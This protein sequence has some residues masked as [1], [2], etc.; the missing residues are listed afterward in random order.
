MRILEE[1]PDDW[2]GH[3]R[4]RVPD[5]RETT[6]GNAGNARLSRRSLLHATGALAGVGVLGLG[7]RTAS[8]NGHERDQ[9]DRLPRP[10]PDVLYEPLAS[11]PQLE[12]TGVWNADPLLVSGTDAYVDGEYLY[13]DYVYDDYG[14]NTTDT[15]APPQPAP[16]DSNAYGENG[17]MTGDVVY[18][19]D[20]DTYRYNAA[21]LLELRATRAGNDVTYRITL[22]T[23]VEPDA[24]AVAIGIDTGESAGTDDWGYGIGS[25]GSLNL[26]HV[27]V[28]WGERAELD[29]EPV[30]SSVDLKRNQIEVTLPLDP[31]EETWRHYAVVGLFDTTAKRF[32]P[33]QNGTSSTHPG[34][35]HGTNPPPVFNVG[36]RFDE[37]VGAP[38]VDR[39]TAETQLEEATTTGS[40]GIGF[41]HWRDHAQATALADRDISHLHTD[42]DFG[43][44]RRRVDERNVPDS[45]LLTRLYAS[46]YDLGEGV[47]AAGDVLR[48]PIQPYTVYVPDEYD[49]ETAT[50]LSLHLHSLGS[51]SSEYGVLSPN[52]IRQLGEQRGAIVLTP[53]GRG[54]QGWYHDEA[55]LDV[56]EAWNDLAARYNVDFDRVTLG[57]YSMGAFGTF[58]L[59]GLYPDLFGKAFAV[60]GGADDVYEASTD[61]FLDSFRNLPVLLWNGTND[62]L[63]P[64]PVYTTTEQRLRTN[65]Y[66]HEIDAFA[67]F[68]HFTFAFLDEWGP[69]REFLDGASVPRT[70]TRVTYRLLPEFDNERFGLVHDTAYWL[71]DMRVAD[72]AR[73]GL[74][75]VRSLAFGDAEPVPVDYERTGT[76]P[77]PHAKRGTEWRTPLADPPA[78]NA[79]ECSLERTTA[80]TVYVEHAGL[81]PD[82]PIELRVDTTHETTITLVSDRAETSVTVP[83]GDSIE[84][85]RL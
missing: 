81:D 80:L 4:S 51:T 6:D 72:D 52:L 54:P 36:F 19:T 64:A 77:A 28:T 73:D 74:T 33:V 49:P 59:G 18:P 65:G 78:R 75:D 5:E 44:L 66:R 69:A 85:V 25:L 1:S 46:R 13:Q 11:A 41:G 27:L 53:E 8:A 47:D 57:G 42:I 20:A 40:R 55:E 15:N 3:W 34:G 62:E 71:T 12:N 45:G 31:G 79:L 61:R 70:P 83:A 29:G 82:D 63:V 2:P 26:D 23:M 48:G 10:G 56:F 84:T 67:G 7:A 16:I 30:E 14:A 37:P 17:V 35:A 24:A 22:N 21:D 60:A 39:G 38:N 9:S 32:K 76:D 58:R 50:P 68:D 43:K